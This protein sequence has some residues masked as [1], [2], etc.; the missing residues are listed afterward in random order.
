MKKL[1]YPLIA[2]F[3]LAACSAQPSPT[4]TLN[5]VDTQEPT[6]LPSATP[7]QATSTATTAFTATPK[8]TAT[9][10]PPT[11]VV[12]PA[13]G[14]GPANFPDGI[15]PLTGQHVANPALLDRRPLLIKVTNLPRDSRPQW[16][17]SQAD[18]VYEYYTELGSTRFSALFYGQ[19]AV[20]V[21]P[22]RSARFFD[23]N[24]ISMYKAVFAFGSAYD[25]VYKELF[26]QP[27]ANRLILEGAAPCP[28]MCRFEPD[29]RNFLITNTSELSK[30]A[31]DKGINQKPSLDG[32]FFQAQAPANGQPLSQV[33]VR[34]SGAIYNR[35]DFDTATGRYL[36]FVDAQDDIDR[37]NEVYTQLVDKN[38]NQPIA[39]DNLVVLLMPYQYYVKTA[40]S[41]VFKM[42]FTGSGTAFAFRDGKAYQLKW[43]RNNALDVV[44][45]T[46]EDGTAY[47]FKPGNTWFEV[48]GASSGLV[49][50]ASDWRFNFVIP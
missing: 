31:T 32:M 1:I 38:N 20:Q 19:D 40:T 6:S 27:Y 23:E 41:E 9:S 12:I 37:N 26:S 35:W 39:A 42:N 8:A 5:L 33:F 3:I 44:S 10:L 17:L 16:G 4:P 22:I 28:P 46:F 29:G 45:L 48:M 25:A 2:I 47:A 14:Y 18:L 15:D 30:Y 21:G 34:F 49:K 13:E 50:Q 11:A 24:L 36:R 7:A 43:V